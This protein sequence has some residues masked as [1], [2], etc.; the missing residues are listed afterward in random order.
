MHTYSLKDG[1]KKF[2]VEVT[3]RRV[4]PERKNTISD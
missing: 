3:V 1:K 2:F 4:A